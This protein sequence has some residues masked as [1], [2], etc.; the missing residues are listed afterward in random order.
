MAARASSS[1]GVPAWVSIYNETNDSGL[2]EENKLFLE[3]LHDANDNPIAELGIFFSKQLVCGVCD[4]GESKKWYYQCW[5][6]VCNLCSFSTCKNLFV[7]QR[8]NGISLAQNCRPRYRRIL[9]YKILKQTISCHPPS[10]H[11]LW[12]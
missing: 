10:R 1:R 9:M 11:H 7:L 6:Q 3:E 2:E 8:S 4:L 12:Q 5:L